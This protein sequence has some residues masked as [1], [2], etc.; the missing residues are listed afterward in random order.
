M[1]RRQDGSNCI[2][3]AKILFYKDSDGARVSIG[4]DELLTE[5]VQPKK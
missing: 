4:S 1:A 5:I 3:K 2:A